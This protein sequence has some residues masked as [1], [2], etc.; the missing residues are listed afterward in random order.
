MSHYPGHEST[1][2]ITIPTKQLSG[3]SGL[4]SPASLT[5]SNYHHS[6]DGILLS[7]IKSVEQLSQ[8]FTR[9]EAISMAGKEH[10]TKNIADAEV[11]VKSKLK[12]DAKNYVLRSGGNAS[13]TPSDDSGPNTGAADTQ[14]EELKRVSTEESNFNKNFGEKDYSSKCLF[15]N[16][17]PT[18]NESL[19]NW[20]ASVDATTPSDY[21]P[22]DKQEFVVR[23][24]AT[25]ITTTV[26]QKPIVT[27]S[28]AIP[29]TA[30]TWSPSMVY[31]QHTVTS[32]STPTAAQPASINSE[33]FIYSL[34][35]K[36]KH[37]QQSCDT[38]AHPVAGDVD[39]DDDADD[40]DDDDNNDNDHLLNENNFTAGCQ[41]CFH[42]TCA[43]FAAAHS[44][45]HH[46]EVYKHKQNL[47]TY[48]SELVS[49]CQFSCFL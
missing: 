41:S 12:T 49:T 23:Q 2:A 14:T 24:I 16:T 1:A 48:S 29:P 37:P 8:S 44:C 3:G 19:T 13:D 28:V 40:D 11:A 17:S 4:S 31:Y 20:Q 34:P 15:N 18:S 39:N 33:T 32:S 38:M 21:M 25:R 10:L 9:I 30:N 22:L 27:P 47:Q 35:V 45:H 26:D 6:P 7:Q 42:P 46:P 5:S 36:H 43:Q